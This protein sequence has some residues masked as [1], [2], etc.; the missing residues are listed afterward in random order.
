MAKLYKSNSG[1][2]ID[3]IVINEYGGIDMLAN[4]LSVNPNLY[5][6]DLVIP[7]NTE[8]ILPAVVVAVVDTKKDKLLW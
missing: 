3:K 8:I 6:L 5:S 4:V 2:R 7:Y 1:E